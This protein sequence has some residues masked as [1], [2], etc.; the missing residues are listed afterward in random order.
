MAPP[1]LFTWFNLEGARMVREDPVLQSK[2]SCLS[3]EWRK[4]MYRIRVKCAEANL[5]A[6]FIKACGVQIQLEEFEDFFHAP[7]EH[8]AKNIKS[9]DYQV[10]MKSLSISLIVFNFQPMTI[11]IIG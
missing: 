2:V 8:I 3:K 10:C 9:T 4:S 6:A 1:C 5:R 7:Q 11:A